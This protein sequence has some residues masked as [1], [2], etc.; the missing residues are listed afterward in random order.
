MANHPN[1]PGDLNQWAKRMVDIA[2]DEVSDREPTRKSAGSIRRR[3]RWARK[4]AQRAPR[5]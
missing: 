5:A 2:T 4:A 3:L 1:R